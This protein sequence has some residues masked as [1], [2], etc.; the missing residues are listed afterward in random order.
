MEV[1]YCQWCETVEISDEV[2]ECPIRYIPNEIMKEHISK[3]FTFRIKERVM[4]EDVHKYKKLYRKSEYECE[5][6]FCSPE[7]CKA[8][9][10]ERRTNDYRY[11]N[12]LALLM[13]MYDISEKIVP[14]SKK[15]K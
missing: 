5:G 14:A 13:Q 1:H 2:I 4:D 7:C 15:K 8:Y 9:I 10:I 3:D 12:S 11:D 6:S